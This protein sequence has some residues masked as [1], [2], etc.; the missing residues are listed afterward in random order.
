MKTLY[1]TLLIFLL[2]FNLFAQWFDQNSGTED[3]F[4]CVFFTDTINGWIG[5]TLGLIYKTTD[6][7]ESWN[8]YTTNSNMDIVSI[9]FINQDTGWCASSSYYGSG[10]GKIYKTTNGGVSWVEIFDGSPILRSISFISEEIGWVVGYLGELLKTYDGGENWMLQYPFGN[11]ARPVKVLF[12]NESTGFVVGANGVHIWKTTDGGNSWTKTYFYH[13]SATQDISF[14][15]DQKGIVVSSTFHQV[16]TE[17]AGETWESF[18]VGIANGF[19]GVEYRFPNI[20]LL[21]SYYNRIINSSNGGNKWFP[22][23]LLGGNHLS[24]IIFINDTVGWVVGFNGTILKTVNG[25]IPVVGNPQRPELLYP[26]NDTS[27]IIIPVH[28]AWND[29]EYSV[30]EFQ[31]A[32]DSLFLNIIQDVALLKSFYSYYDLILTKYYWRVRSEN[33]NGYSDWSEIR[34]F[35][36]EDLLDIHNYEL[37]REYSLGQNFPNPF[38]PSTTINYQIPELNFVT[39]KVSDV[40]GREFTTLINEEKPAGN[41]EVEFNG[42]NLPSGIYFYRLQAGEFVETKKM[43]LLK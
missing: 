17:N 30:Y 23:K 33:L 38:N 6:G 10:R 24:D 39:I 37:L 32:L 34:S 5:S 19:Y 25:G 9:Q 11:P 28:F 12:L 20:W 35:K 3:D 18:E 27:L 1:I 36:M 31:L 22:Q 26:P 16:K 29:L 21:S 14:S 43:V 8:S 42:T 7:G 2:P 15:N 41:Y 40:L 4:L 13:S